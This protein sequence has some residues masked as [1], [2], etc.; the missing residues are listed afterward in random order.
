VPGIPQDVQVVEVTK[1]SATITWKAPESDGGSPIVGYVIERSLAGKDRWLRAN[2]QLV[3]ELTYCVPELVED[4]EYVF[5]VIAENKV[6]QG[7]PSDPT[8]PVVARD[9]WRECRRLPRYFCCYSSHTEM[10][11]TDSYF[12]KLLKRLLFRLQPGT[13]HIFAS[14]DAEYG[15]QELISCFQPPLNKFFVLVCS[16]KPGKPDPPQITSTTNSTASLAYKPPADDGGAEITNYV[17]EYREESLSKWTRATKD[18]VSKTSYT[19]TGLKKDTVYEFRVAAENK[20]GVGPASD[21][22]SPAAVKEIL[23]E[24]DFI[25]G[26]ISLQIEASSFVELNLLVNGSANNNIRRPS[27]KYLRLPY[28]RHRYFVIVS[29]DARF[30]L[31]K[32]CR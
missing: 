17:I 6:G 5:R 30:Q 4:N 24:Y 28:V 21:P 27:L 14:A 31:N 7:Q 18:T 32:I 26:S 15:K 16:E 22:S 3:P 11:L 9:P 10:S 23:S 8:K 25:F 13:A 1:T 29:C 12:L 20:A 2:N 19:V